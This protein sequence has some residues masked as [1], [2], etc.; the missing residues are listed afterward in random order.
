MPT[1]ISQVHMSL[2]PVP[3]GETLAEI[4]SLTVEDVLSLSVAALVPC[5]ALSSVSLSGVFSAA[6]VLAVK[7]IIIPTST[8]FV[9]GLG[10]CAVVFTMATCCLA[11]LVGFCGK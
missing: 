2:Y 10:I 7:A 4:S 8:I 11:L 6:P 1:F 9:P 5:I 3:L